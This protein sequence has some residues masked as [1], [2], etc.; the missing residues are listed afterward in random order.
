MNPVAAV[1]AALNHLVEEDD[2]LPFFAHL[3]SKIAQPRKLLVEGG[4]L[5]VMGCEKRQRSKL[6]RIM[7]VLEDSL[8]NADPVVGAS[9]AAHLVEDEQ[10]AGRGMG[11]DV[12]R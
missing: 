9:A 4:Q 2:A 7:E 11:E 8:R 6:R 1:G 10:A 12:R 5:V 3:H